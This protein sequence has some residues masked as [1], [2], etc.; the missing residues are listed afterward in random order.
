VPT[1]DA[2]LP[3]GG[4]IDSSF[5]AR[6][7]TDVKAL[8]K[9]GEQTILERTIAALRGTGRVGRTIVI[10]GREVHIEADGLATEVLDEGASGP[11]NILKGLK[12]LVGLPDPPKKVLVVTTDMPFLTAE[13][14]N[15]F[16]DQCPQERDICVPLVSKAEWFEKFPNSMATFATLADGVWTTGCAYLI[17]VTALETAMPQIERVF[18]NRKSVVGMAKLLGPRFLFKFV[19]KTLNVLD[20][21]LKITTMLGCTGA[22]IRN[23]PTE[24]AY[25]IDDLEDYEYAHAHFPDK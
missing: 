9:F 17:D 4:R 23:A 21:E 10:G 8:I 7:G 19:T 11:D 25:D 3:A 20:V 2:I 24:L 18:K 12:H 6:V 1:Y 5:A 16:L 14:I 13:V 15:R 22:A